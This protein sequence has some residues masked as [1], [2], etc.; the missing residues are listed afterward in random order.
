MTTQTAEGR[1][2][3]FRDRVITEILKGG[4]S[5]GNQ[6]EVRRR[7]HPH[8]LRPAKAAIEVSVT[9]ASQAAITDSAFA[10]APISRARARRLL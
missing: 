8:R 2:K 7:E 10:S 3:I 5:S 6:A 4:L 9:R 1:R